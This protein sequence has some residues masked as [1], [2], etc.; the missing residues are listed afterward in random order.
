MICSMPLLLLCLAI[1]Q[2]FRFVS[3]CILLPGLHLTSDRLAKYVLKKLKL[4]TVFIHLDHER[5]IYAV[6]GV[7]DID[8]YIMQFC[9]LL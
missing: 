3:L 7:F 2:A 8:F 4:K 5:P 9:A 1:V 6:Y